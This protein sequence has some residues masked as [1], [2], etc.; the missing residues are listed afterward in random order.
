MGQQ[1]RRWSLPSDSVQRLTP[2]SGI[3]RSPWDKGWRDWQLTDCFQQP[4]RGLKAFADLVRTISLV[5][6]RHFGMWRAFL[7]LSEQ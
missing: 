2:S 1:W 4:M 5:V 6:K 3:R 7:I